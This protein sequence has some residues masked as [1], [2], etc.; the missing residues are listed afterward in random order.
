MEGCGPNCARVILIFFNIIFWISGLALLAIGIWILVDPTL[1][2][3]IDLLAMLIENNG[4]M[5]KYA[6]YVLIAV[7]LF[8]AIVG[9]FGCCG[10]LKENKC[11][12]GLYVFLLVI[13]MLGEIGIAVL[14]ILFQGS[15][16]DKLDAQFKVLVG[17]YLDPA[18]TDYNTDPAR[19]FNQ[20]ISNVEKEL[21][22]CGYNGIADYESVTGVVVPAA[23]GDGSAVI[24]GCKEGL[25][26]FINQQ[27]LI[28]IGIGVGIAC[29]EIFGIIFGICLCRNVD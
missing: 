21:D 22:C 5:L 20:T 18:S 25:E 26:A 10:A 29:L 16:N 11:L 12:L 17:K 8:V 7:G 13:V 1:L 3:K 28:V 9:F 14:A 19:A 4:D 27:S 15:V 23:C 2:Q 24:A 6:S